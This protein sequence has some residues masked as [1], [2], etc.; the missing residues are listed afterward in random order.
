MA[1]R[2]MGYGYVSLANGEN[3]RAHLSA[4]AARI[5]SACGYDMPDKPI[6]RTCGPHALTWRPA[7][8]AAASQS[9]VECESGDAAL[10]ALIA[11]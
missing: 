2:R 4:A 1:H 10:G 5:G 3:G 8:T 9:F 11:P 6:T 7:Q